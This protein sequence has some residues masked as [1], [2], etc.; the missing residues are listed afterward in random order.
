MGT[1]LGTWETPQAIPYELRIGV[2]GHQ[3]LDDPAAVRGA[4]DALLEH[5]HDTLSAAAEFPLG[6]QSAPGWRVRNARWLLARCTKPIWRTLPV[7]TRRVREENRTPV[8]WTVVSAL[9][10][11]AD[12]IVVDAVLENQQVQGERRL[13][14]LLP[15][16][17]EVYREHVLGAEAKEAFDR[18]MRGASKTIVLSD[19]THE[20]VADSADVRREAYLRAGRATVDAC[21]ILIAIWDGQAD[22][23]GVGTGAMVKYAV[24][25]D[26][27]V[28]WI[29]AGNPSGPI[30]QLLHDEG[31]GQRWRVAPLPD[32]ARELSPGFFSLAAYNRDPAH[33]RVRVEKGIAAKS[34][35]LRKIAHDVQL[36]EACVEPLL[37]T[38][39]PH[40]VRSSR[41]ADRYQSLY[42]T[43]AGW[44]Y[45]L[46]ALSVTIPVVQALFLPHQAW[47]IGFEVLALLTILVLLEIGRHQGWHEKWL[48]DRHLA[49]RLRTAM[50]TVL[51][52][53][54]GPRSHSAPERF[55]PYYGARGA[56]VGQAANWLTRQAFA[57]RCGEERVDA[58]R[59]FIRQ[60]W[61]EEQIGYHRKS[62]DRHRHKNHR[63]HW[64][65]LVFFL[66]TLIAALL[67]AFGVGHVEGAH[68]LSA[69]VAL[70]FAL[71]ALSIALPAWGASVHA[72]NT[73]LDHDRVSSRSDGMYRLLKYEVAPDIEQATSLEE[74]RIAVERAAELMMRE[75]YEW[76]T[77]LAFH[78]LHRPG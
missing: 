16:K 63:A 21:E 14:V 23:N 26:R 50:F 4:V 72:V 19:D 13:E 56:W 77:S 9:A 32:T 41:L 28:L 58:L 8:V 45:G 37:R 11:G 33:D 2:T 76:L 24:E 59:E 1:A 78:E 53:I 3:K 48:Q 61:I 62:K 22:D 30:Q 20:S 64:I 40:S 31:S 34:E 42:T 51:V 65:G 68:E 27:F 39:L 54:A 10:A 25:R 70:G 15:F 38:L 52:D 67:H 71:I 66:V 29:D 57:Q 18:L 36:S 5:L 46:A 43:A 49:E 60:A 6:R 73:M 35:E 44:L 12:Q 47:I 17:E 55:L 69:W 7:P 74:L 75:N